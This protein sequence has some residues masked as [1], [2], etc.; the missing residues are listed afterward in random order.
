MELS[1]CPRNSLNIT[2]HS[3]QKIV[4]WEKFH[5]RDLD[6]LRQTVYFHTRAIVYVD[7]FLLRNRKQL[8]IVKPSCISYSLSK[9]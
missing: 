5:I 6:M 9:L 2:Y 7:I 4:I 8:V 1:A 3:G